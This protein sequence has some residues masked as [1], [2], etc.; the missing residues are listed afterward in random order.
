MSIEQNIARMAD[1]L[2]GLLNLA[3]AQGGLVTGPSIAHEGKPESRAAN[4][5]KNAAKTERKLAEAAKAPESAPQTDDEEIQPEVKLPDL[6]ATQKAGAD[7][8][9]LGEK[10][11][12]A[13]KALIDKF[14]D[15]KLPREGDDA[16][17]GVR[18]VP[19]TKRQAFIDEAAKNR[20][21]VAD[22]I[23]K[24]DDADEAGV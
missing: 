7:L 11:K 16:V 13:L 1:A 24:Q 12:A 4:A 17:K 2:E 8:L 3:K 15:K 6:A 10:G 14:E 22:I 18:R 21:Q 23:A 5:V 20:K 19:E 9:A